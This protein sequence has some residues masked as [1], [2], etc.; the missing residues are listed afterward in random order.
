MKAV[1]S[2]C[3]TRGLNTA[4]IRLLHH[5]SNAVV[6]LPSHG[7][8]VRVASGRHDVAQIRRSQDVTRWLVDHHGFGATRPLPGVDLVEVDATTTV[9]FWVNYPQPA[10]PRPLTSAHMGC[11]LANL[12]AIPDSP[13]DL[14]RWVPLVRVS[15]WSCGP[16]SCCHV[17]RRAMRLHPR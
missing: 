4:G 16:D 13:P 3:T 11:L 12:H 6:L 17:R 5:S 1:C 10:P 14:P 9:S 2:A 8:V 7:A 15:C